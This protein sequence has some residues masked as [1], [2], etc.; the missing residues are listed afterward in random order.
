MKKIGFKDLKKILIKKGFSQMTTNKIK[1][2]VNR[3]PDRWVEEGTR[4]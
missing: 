3:S 2:C 4:Q 1:M